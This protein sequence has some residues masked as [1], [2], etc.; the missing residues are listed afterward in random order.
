MSGQD[1]VCL[2]CQRASRITRL[3]KLRRGY[4]SSRQR[5][6]EPYILRR[7]VI[8]LD[9]SDNKY[10]RPAEDGETPAPN[11]Q[12]R[13]PRG[14]TIQRRPARMLKLKGWENNGPFNIRATTPLD[15]L[16]FALEGPSIRR[17]RW[18][19]PATH[20]NSQLPEL[21]KE[22]RILSSDSAQAKLEQLL[23]GFS[24]D[25]ASNLRTAGFGVESGE[26]I[27]LQLRKRY[28]SFRD[29]SRAISM[30]SSTVDGCRF[31]ATGGAVGGGI[32]S[33]YEHNPHNHSHE[34]KPPVFA[35]IQL[36]NNLQ[37]NM[38]SK[39][40][41]IGPH[42]C[43]VGLLYSTMG[44]QLQ[45]TMKYIQTMVDNGYHT[46]GS[47]H[48]ALTALLSGNWDHTRMSQTLPDEPLVDANS[49]RTAF[50]VLTG[51][52]PE[53]QFRPLEQRGASFATLIRQDRNRDFNIN[54]YPAYI[55]TL[56]KMGE[57]KALLQEFSTIQ[58]Q[59]LPDILRGANGSSR[60]ACL[61]AVA[62]VLAK[63][64]ENA[65]AVL[66]TGFADG[67]HESEGDVMWTIVSQLY[68]AHHIVV[69][70]SLERT[71]KDFVGK[72]WQTALDLITR[73][74]DLDSLSIPEGRHWRSADWVENEDGIGHAVVKY[75]D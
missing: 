2:L 18:Q 61:H 5:S 31:L 12:D 53:G 25:E 26:S 45:S 71:L 43:G 67:S 49:R 58:D 6:R 35:I 34:Q 9:S 48:H 33:C 7:L 16:S 60:K 10:V 63:D 37:V 24:S 4:S 20:I 39:G 17:R 66:K 65:A 41:S 23:D 47:T 50:S 27:N 21:F 59:N 11:V 74:I 52:D 69:A 19:S 54:L 3:P 28:T 72:D 15:I 36:L 73:L 46:G 38:N 56:G 42:L 29:F 13:K 51:C 68:R 62:F 14:F 55:I 30:L 44:F 70:G 75:L 1:A 57:S 32:K 22:R 8:D 40:I 64:L